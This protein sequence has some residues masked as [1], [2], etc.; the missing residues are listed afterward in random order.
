MSFISSKILEL[1]INKTK[2]SHSSYD[3]DLEDLREYF[4]KQIDRD[5]FE[6][7]CKTIRDCG[8]TSHVNL[9]NKI[10]NAYNN[11]CLTEVEIAALK[12]ISLMYKDQV[13]EKRSRKGKGL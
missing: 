1:K 4:Y 7:L 5:D 3:E 8:H 11:D 6:L 13:L 12:K 2:K 9:V 10:E